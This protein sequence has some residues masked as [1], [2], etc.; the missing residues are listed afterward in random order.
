MTAG[1]QM[2]P[3]YATA[4][5][6]FPILPAPG[7][8][9]PIL[10]DDEPSGGQAWEHGLRG[11]IPVFQVAAGYVLPAS[12]AFHECGH[13]FDYTLDY[14]ST[15]FPGWH[16]KPFWDFQIARG[17]IMPASSWE[18]ALRIGN[19]L[20]GMAQWVMLPGERWAECFKEAMLG[21]D[22]AALAFFTE[23]MYQ[24]R[25]SL[26]PVRS[27]PAPSGV[28]DVR[29]LLPCQGNIF[30]TFLPKDSLTFHWNGPALDLTADPLD[31]LK[32]DAA[33]HIGKGWGGI[34]YHKAIWTDGT[35]YLC[36][37]QDAVLA[38]CGDAVGNARS[39]HVQVMV[40]EGQTPTPAQW[41]RMAELA[42]LETTVHSHKFWSS[43][44]CPGSE[45]SDWIANKR[46][47]DDMFTDDDRAKLNRVY[48]H[49]E[50]YE[51]MTWV[52]RLQQWLAKAFRSMPVTA[53]AD[54][55]GPD[56]KTGE[57]FK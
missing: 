28:V 6:A 51:P 41:A 7:P 29:S 55:S 32:A 8:G 23:L 24:A 42:S 57:P 47:E 48:A 31:L 10:L 37:D 14:W 54:L 25:P 13:A 20:S 43:T 21:H 50:A 22:P 1:Q 39:Q 17:V 12:D 27:A 33:F 5:A 15:T 9:I 16:H 3:F 53:N 45:I 4:Q 26:R 30:G 49:L 52:S 46:W 34:S 2:L 11:A 44:S 56:V 36:R 18:E 38:A 40:G 19:T 35:L